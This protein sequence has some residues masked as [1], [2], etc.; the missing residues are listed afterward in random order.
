MFP[1]SFALDASPNVASTR[2]STPKRAEPSYMMQYHC[3]SLQ[4]YQRYRDNFSPALQKEHSDRFGGRF[5]G[6]R[7]LLE[8]VGR[9][10][11]AQ[12]DAT[13]VV[14]ARRWL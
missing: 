14:E 5:R 1:M 3:R 4:E 13:R 12:E 8:E 9:A 2:S 7:Q 11:R 10:T 6:V